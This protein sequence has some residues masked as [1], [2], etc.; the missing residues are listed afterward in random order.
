M[1]SY[2]TKQDLFTYALARGSLA[3]M[4]R[5]ADAVEAATDTF[6][7]DEHG[8]VTNDPITV[9]AAEGGSLPAPLVKGTTYYVIRLTDATFQVAAAANGSAIDLTTDGQSVV[10]AGDLPFDQILAVETAWIN[11]CIPEAPS[12]AED[13]K[14]A[15][16]AYPLVLIDTTCQLAAARLLT[17]TGARSEL[18]DEA[19]KAA[20]DTLK[21]W[22]AGLPVRGLAQSINKAIVATSSGGRWGDG[23]C[24]P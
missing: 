8:F 13:Y 24:I 5:L 18:L 3:S 6:E 23:S 4:G 17:M 20:R 11:Q 10:V 19:R 21:E 16:G 15:N 9:R 2:A 14:T 12:A 1:A 22:R 7:L